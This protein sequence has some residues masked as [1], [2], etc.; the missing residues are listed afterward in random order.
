MPQLSF[1]KNAL[2]I[3]AAESSH[4]IHTTLQ[5][6]ERL[7]GRIVHVY[8]PR[9]LIGEIPP[10]IEAQVR[11]LANIAE[12]HRGRVDLAAVERFGPAAVQAVKGWNRGFAASFRAL[13]SGRA[14]EGKSWGSPDHAPEGPV[15]PPKGWNEPRSPRRDQP[16]P[17]PGTSDYLIGKVAVNIII[18]EGKSSPYSFTPMERDTVV[19][20]VQDGLGWLGSLEPKAR[21]SWF[22]EIRTVTLDLDPAQVPDFSEDTWRDAA[23]AQLGYPASWDGLEQFVRA[24][25]TALGTDWTLAIFITRFPLWHFAYAF[26][27]RIVMNY[28]LDSW[29]IEDMDRIV[30]HETGHIFGAADEY[31]ESK[32]SCSER[33]GYLQIENGNCELCAPT[34]VECIMSHNTWAMCE[35]TRGQLGWRDSNGDGILDPLDEPMPTTASVRLYSRLLEWLRRWLSTS[36]LLSRATSILPKDTAG[37][38]TELN[39]RL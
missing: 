17:G 30:A 35:Y 22:Y 27:P 5:E 24:R 33:F 2:L 20:E 37:G 14:S 21:V 26:K 19:A 15:Q 32:C 4:I 11:A 34:H 9:I 3:L 18:V 39:R 8:P 13:K 29:G 31:A 6:I 36:R 25:R 38:H 1:G 23:M 28:D 12:F 7:G 10:P 16:A